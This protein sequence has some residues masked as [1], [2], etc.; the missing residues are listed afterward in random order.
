MNT[1][2]IK[3]LIVVLISFGLG[4]AQSKTSRSHE[5]SDFSAENAGVTKPIPIPGD[6]LPILKKDEMVRDAL[7]S[8]NLSAEKLPLSWFSAAAVHLASLDRTDLVVM[9]AGPL[10]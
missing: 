9:A 2:A 3:L 5:Q 1:R 10:R 7:D 6:V 4:I 8:E